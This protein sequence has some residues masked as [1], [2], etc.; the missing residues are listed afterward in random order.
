M[1]L[2]KQVLTGLSFIYTTEE[3]WHQC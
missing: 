3:S 2:M 1:G